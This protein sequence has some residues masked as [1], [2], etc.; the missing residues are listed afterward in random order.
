MSDLEKHFNNI[1]IAVEA[2][3]G[4]K[5]EHVNLEIALSAIKNELFKKDEK[6]PIDNTIPANV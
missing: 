3:K 1:V 5:Q 2:Y 4:T 6:P